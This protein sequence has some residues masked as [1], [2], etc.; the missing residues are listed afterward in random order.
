MDGSL[1]AMT[2]DA[3]TALLILSQQFYAYDLR[4]FLQ[5]VVEASGTKTGISIC[6]LH[7]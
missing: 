5:V 1:A 3:F 2:G 4:G 6:G 7:G